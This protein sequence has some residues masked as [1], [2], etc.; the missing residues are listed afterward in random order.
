MA[1][2]RPSSRKKIL[3]AAADL[4]RQ[5][6]PVRFSL[7]AVASHAGVSKGGLL[8]NFPSKAKL[9]QGL[10]EEYLEQFEQDLDAAVG[11]D[12][13]ESLLAAYVRLSAKD[14]ESTQPAAA[15][16]FAAMAEDPDFLEPIHAF[17]DRLL[18]RLRAEASDPTAMLVTFLAVEGLRNMKL[19]GS[20]ILTPEERHDVLASLLASADAASRRP[21]T[22]D[23]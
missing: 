8:Y 23:A 6:G 10:V 2:H 18:D 13:D 4:A 7:D 12:R 1:G 19:F 11:P 16:I 14:C 21:A 3:A 9:M 22:T 20:K 17:R 5:S 15:W